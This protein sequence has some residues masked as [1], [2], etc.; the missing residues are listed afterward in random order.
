MTTFCSISPL[1]HSRYA[2]DIVKTL[3][4]LYNCCGRRCCCIMICLQLKHSR[5]P[6]CWCAVL[7]ISFTKVIG[8]ILASRLWLFVKLHLLLTE[9]LPA[10]LRHVGECAHHPARFVIFA[11]LALL[12]LFIIL[13]FPILPFIRTCK[14]TQTVSDSNNHNVESLSGHS[15]RRSRIY[16]SPCII[17]LLLNCCLSVFNSLSCP[18]GLSLNLSLDP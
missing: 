15:V 1:R 18:S 14:I 5:N 4:R 8:W 10:L 13:I 17:L 9:P 2:G 12:C 16:N 11:Q 6:Q 7:H 3:H